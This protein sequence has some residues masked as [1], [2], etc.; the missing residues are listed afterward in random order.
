MDVLYTLT[1]T[2][3]KKD[4]LVHIT[5]LGAVFHEARAPG[6]DFSTIMPWPL[7]VISQTTIAN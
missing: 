3:P 1:T 5:S 4:R 2:G 6:V 7:P